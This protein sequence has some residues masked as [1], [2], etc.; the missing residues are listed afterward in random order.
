MP[1]WKGD[2]SSKVLINIIFR[3]LRSLLCLVCFISIMNLDLEI[4]PQQDLQILAMFLTRMV[5]IAAFDTWI[6]LFLLILHKQEIKYN[7]FHHLVVWHR[8]ILFSQSY[9]IKWLHLWS[10]ERSGHCIWIGI[11]S[12]GFNVYQSMENCYNVKGINVVF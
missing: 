3:L 5:L 6:L 8:E 10:V 9:A 11:K 12:F 2:G 4:K 1:V 7:S